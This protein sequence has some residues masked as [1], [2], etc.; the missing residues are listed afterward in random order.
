M[1]KAKDVVVVGSSLGGF[2]VALECAKLGL[3][4]AVVA[5]RF[6]V[7]KSPLA[8]NDEGLRWLAEQ[9]EGVTV[10]EHPPTPQLVVAHDGTQRELPRESILGIPSS[11]LSEAVIQIIG[12]G[13]ATKAYLDRIKP[14]LTIGKE[15]ELGTLVEKRMGRAV[16]TAMVEPVVFERFGLLSNRVEASVAVP[17]LNEALTRTGSLA[18]AVLA[19]GEVWQKHTKRYEITDLQQTIRKACDFWQI[20]LIDNESGDARVA[21]LKKDAR[22]LVLA[23]DLPDAD[24][25]HNANFARWLEAAKPAVRDSVTVQI[26]GT[27]AALKPG[28]VAMVD[29]EK[30]GP[31]S[32]C[33]LPEQHLYKV[34]LAARELGSEQRL[35]GADDIARIFVNLHEL[36]E[37]SSKLPA[38]SALEATTIIRRSGIE[39][40]PTAT[41]G[42]ENALIG[43]QAEISETEGEKPVG[44]WLAGGDTSRAI[45]QAKSLAVEVRRHLLGIA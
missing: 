28:L 7:P 9:L 16:L 43:I 21:Q 13:N 39:I 37:D 31:V 4:V 14:V 40:L 34:C 10:V 27:A 19:L 5:D 42:Q 38:H 17:G 1:S 20:E 11:A 44:L 30:F 33:A 6:E 41:R 8:D 3:K 23:D 25:F 35:I 26:D 12:K 18:N 2:V 29:D 36:I 15:K 24:A 32:V 22:Q 45:N